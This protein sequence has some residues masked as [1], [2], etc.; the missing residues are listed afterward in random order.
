M[1]KTVVKAEKS[2]GQLK[3]VHARKKAWDD[4]NKE[5]DKQKKR[6]ESKETSKDVWETDEEMDGTEDEAEDKVPEATVV[7]E[8]V[9]VI[10]P[11]K[12]NDEGEIL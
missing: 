5:T 12:G 2:R 7:S 9:P 1:E 6:K 3:T 11:P 4:I 8:D 10:E